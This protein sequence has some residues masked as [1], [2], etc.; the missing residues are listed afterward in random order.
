MPEHLRLGEKNM[1]HIVSSLLCS[2]V[3]LVGAST[4]ARADIIFLASPSF[5]QPDENLN[6]NEPGLLAGPALTVQGI[7][8]QSD[9]VFNLTGTENLVTPAAGQARVEDEGA[10][11]FTSLLIDAFDSNIFFRSFEANLNAEADGR[12]FITAIDSDG[13][14]FLFNFILSGAG[15]NF[16]GLKAINGQVIDTVL[17]TTNVDLEDVRQIRLGGI[18]EGDEPDP[19]V[20][21]PA[22]LALLGVGLASAAAAKRRRR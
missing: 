6:F 12:A 9:T 2:G 14:E 10:N 3:L 13:Q 21:E 4:Q 16:F 17:I 19:D 20:P 15:Q 5:V 18:Q 8:N 7:T 11:G 22:T 1:K